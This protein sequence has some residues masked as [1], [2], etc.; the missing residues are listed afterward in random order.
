MISGN[1]DC[2]D[3]YLGR[4]QSRLPSAGCSHLMIIEQRGIEKE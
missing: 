1:T 3:S 4:G 2:F